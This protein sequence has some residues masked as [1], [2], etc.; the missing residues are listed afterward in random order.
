VSKSIDLLGLDLDSN[1]IDDLALRKIAIKLQKKVRQ[2]SV[3]SAQRID[4]RK[5]SAELP[6]HK[7]CAR[8]AEKL[9]GQGWEALPDGPLRRAMS[10]AK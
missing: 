4:V 10:G 2:L 3:G 8:E 7:S 1:K 6:A 5:L 9:N